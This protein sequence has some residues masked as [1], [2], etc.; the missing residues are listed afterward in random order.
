[1]SRNFLLHSKQ[2]SDQASNKSV[3]ATAAVAQPQARSRRM[4]LQQQKEKSFID[5][6]KS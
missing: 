6:K 4:A 1:L 2:A 3:G 5:Q